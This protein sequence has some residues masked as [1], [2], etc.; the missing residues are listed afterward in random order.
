MCFYRD[1]MDR[2][3]EG[4]VV[5]DRFDYWTSHKPYQGYVLCQAVNRM[6]SATTSPRKP[7]DWQALLAQVDKANEELRSC[8]S[9]RPEDK[10]SY[11]SLVRWC[12]V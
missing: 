7:I 11:D 2:H 1:I 12:F 5:G 8:P 4:K 3:P 6:R 9:A 10:E